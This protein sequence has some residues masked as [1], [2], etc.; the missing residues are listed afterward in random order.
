MSP[1]GDWQ[2]FKHRTWYVVHKILH[3][4]CIQSLTLWLTLSPL[5]PGM[6]APPLSP[7]I[8]CRPGGPWAPAEPAGPMAPCYGAEVN[9]ERLAQWLQ[10]IE[11]QTENLLPRL[12]HIEY[13]YV[14]TCYRCDRVQYVYWCSQ[15]FRPQQSS[16]FVATFEIAFAKTLGLFRYLLSQSENASTDSTTETQTH[17]VCACSVQGYH[18]IKKTGR[19]V[20]KKA[21]H[22]NR[23]L[24]FLD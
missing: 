8:P 13:K 6:P 14:I 11:I 7:G 16:S 18:M 12:L 5:G 3:I 23:L 4:K 21:H 17:L 9:V 24:H 20:W 19:T 15:G 10:W 22:L 1:Y 2:R